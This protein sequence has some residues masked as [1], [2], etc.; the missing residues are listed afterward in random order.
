MKVLDPQHDP[1][2]WWDRLRSATRRG[3]FLDYDGTLA[4]FVVDPAKAAPHPG[5]PALL[6][7]IV[8]AGRTRV[9]LITGRP[10]RELLPLLGMDRAPEIWGCHGWER[11]RE[12]GFYE[13][14]PVPVAALK[15][16]E[17]A[18]RWI[19]KR[20]RCE[21]KPAAAALHWRGLPAKE[22]QALREHAMKRWPDL[23][24]GAALEIG[25]F[26]GGIEIRVAGRD[27]G[28]AVKTLLSELGEGAV[29]AYLG[30]DQTDEDAF[31]AI[32]GS[33]LGVLVR[34]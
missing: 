25:E 22:A 11:L 10:A 27:K 8:A 29:A 19:G 14:A 24:K 12:D 15:A 21:A 5:V 3:L 33:G 23:A 4:P 26:D 9:V 34:E 28:F 6:D 13:L 32:R 31:R 20:G 16:L 30:D 7:G 18:I 2:A 17:E 1:A